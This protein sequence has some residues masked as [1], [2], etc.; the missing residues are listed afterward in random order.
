MSFIEKDKSNRQKIQLINRILK[1]PDEKLN[2]NIK[3]DIFDTS[4]NEGVIL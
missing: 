4:N 1:T 2:K 3:F